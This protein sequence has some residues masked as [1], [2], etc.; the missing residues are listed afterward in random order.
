M[1]SRW[2]T[3]QATRPFRF[4]REF[5]DEWVEDRSS[6]MA[7]E[8][9]F[10]GLLGVFPALLVMAATLGWLE[11]WIGTTAA[12]RAQQ[13]LV[14]RAIDV[15]G[16]DSEVPGVIADLFEGTNAGAFTVGVVIALY[17]ASRGFAAVVRAIDVAYDHPDRRGWLGARAVGLGLA[18]GTVLVGVLVVLLL[19]IGP[20]LGSGS[21]VSDALGGGNALATVW[22]YLR[23]PVAIVVMIAWAAT[24]YHVA[25]N[26]RTP[27]RWDLPGAGVAMVLWI[28]ATW[29]FTVYLDF[30]VEGGNAVLGLLGG[31]ITMVLWFYL[32]A[33]G[34]LVGAEVNAIL[35][36][37][38]DVGRARRVPTLKGVVTHV[39]G[40]VA[41]VRREPSEEPDA[42]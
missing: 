10:F 25:P 21:D 31:A 39:R 1:H 30:A 23:W 22:D 28:I 17:T 15:F 16:A 26:R 13:W 35:S 3:L 36:R 24:I 42:Q 27:W 4:F 7:A 8:I 11:T 19:I 38:H 32:L 9:A 6:G 33:L 5:I 20:F 41:D 2:R 12:A 29:G 18:L 14:D 34:L 40:A 37:H